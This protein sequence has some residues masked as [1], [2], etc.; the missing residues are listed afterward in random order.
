MNK[1][2]DRNLQYLTQL[3]KDEAD[4]IEHILL[5]EVEQKSAFLL[6][7]RIFEEDINGNNTEGDHKPE[8]E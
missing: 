6:A 2:I 7:K 1:A 3:T 8:A 5:W 4:F